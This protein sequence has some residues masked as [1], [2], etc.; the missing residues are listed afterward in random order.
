MG[1]EQME[2]SMIVVGAIIVTAFS[3]VANDVTGT[4]RI[5]S[6]AFTGVVTFVVAVSVVRRLDR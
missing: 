6:A 4:L 1:I 5:A 3:W 2:L